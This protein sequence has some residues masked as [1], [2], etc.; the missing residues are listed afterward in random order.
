MVNNQ[1]K[2]AINQASTKWL[3]KYLQSNLPLLSLPS[4]DYQDWFDDFIVVL[5]DRDLSTPFQQRN[6]LTDVRNAIKTLD[7][8]HPALDIVKFDKETWT[9][10]N[11]TQSDRI[12]ERTTKFIDNP[13]A[14]V[15]RATVL[16]GSYQWSE[17]AAGLAVV[18]GRRCTEIIKTAQFE[19]K[20]KYSVIFTGALKRKNE[21]VECVFE[22]PTLCEA[23]LVID[24]IANLKTQLG[25]EIQSLSKR[26]VSSRYSKGV[27][28]KCDRYFDE[29]VPPREDKD[30]LYTHLFRAVYATIASYWY[31]PP[32]IPEMEFR[33]AI[34]GHYQILDEKN[35]QLRRSLAAGRNYFDYKIGDGQGNIDGRLGIKLSLPDVEVIEQFQHAYISQ[36][37]L[38]TPGSAIDQK[39]VINPS[40]P[41]DKSSIAPHNE[42][43]PPQPKPTMNEQSISA[44]NTAIAIPSFLLSRLDAIANQLGL[45][46]GEA[47]QALFAWTEV[48][49]SLTNNLEIDEKTPEAL[50]T[51]VEELRQSNSD[52]P[53]LEQSTSPDSVSNTPMSSFSPQ[54]QKQMILTVFNSVELLSKA[55]IDKESD[56]ASGASV[57]VTQQKTAKRIPSSSS[58]PQ[59][60]PNT[61]ERDRSH[62]SN[63]TNSKNTKQS[64]PKVLSETR[65]RDSST[66][67]DEDINGAIDAVM[68]FNDTP[69]RP[70]KQKFRLSVKPLSDLCGRANNS[71]AALLKDRREE[72]DRHHEKHE[73]S[74]YHNKSRK[75]KDG[76]HYPPI[77]QESEINY[78]KVTEI[79]DS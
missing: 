47:I 77:E 60:S 17:I 2:E 4:T 13:D 14:I 21:P 35:P 11:R 62:N 67:V 54:E 46:Q 72:I 50:F 55:L 69:G 36:S 1:L 59:N 16:L 27:A 44:S 64:P 66:V 34:Q 6:Y 18:T 30:N 9:Q 43:N 5:E 68:E 31:C 73:L 71:I 70:H 65:Q 33:A 51:S 56:R 53:S 38:S 37:S 7:P 63:N 8:N 42:T 75:N 57:K 19:Y 10:I 40:V 29:L 25:K 58:T 32:T 79:L 3:Q 22:I 15:K 61:N 24:A 78:Q 12:A 20:T 76:V 45:S 41:T 52:Q 48:G 74:A 49:I 23:Q 39:E 28:T 26:Q